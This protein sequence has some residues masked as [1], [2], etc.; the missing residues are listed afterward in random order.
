MHPTRKTLA[1]NIK[2][3]YYLLH[4]HFLDLATMN[5][6]F[7]QHRLM[8]IHLEKVQQQP[9]LVEVVLLQSNAWCSRQPTVLWLR[10]SAHN[11]WQAKQLIVQVL[12]QVW[13]AAS[14]QQDFVFCASLVD[15]LYSQA[16]THPGLHEANKAMAPINA[17]N[18]TRVQW[19]FKKNMRKLD[20]V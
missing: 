10:S 12:L 14:Q 15:D 2:F 3:S 8:K 20:T 18:S 7:L 9:A 16:K 11:L 1:I 5:C 6:T 4:E 19:K 13:E 17:F